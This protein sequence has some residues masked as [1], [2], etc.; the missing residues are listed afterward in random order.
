MGSGTYCLYLKQY[1][2]MKQKNLISYFEGLI[3]TNSELQLHNF[4][5]AQ[6]WR[7]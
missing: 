7:L 6:L 2:T 4:A 3:L 5:V 1:E